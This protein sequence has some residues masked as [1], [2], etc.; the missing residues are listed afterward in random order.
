[1]VVLGLGVL[2]AFGGVQLYQLSK[3][4]KA[5]TRMER[6]RRKTISYLDETI[7]GKRAMESEHDRDER[8]RQEETE[9]AEKA[10]KEKEVE[11]K[12]ETDGG[13][14]RRYIPLWTQA[15]G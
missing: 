11:G 8:R 6:A 14:W 3:D 2:C 10:R 1:M 4:D 12:K 7:G 15:K 5:R 13:G 9:K